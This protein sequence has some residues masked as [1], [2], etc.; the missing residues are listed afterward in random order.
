MLVVQYCT[1]YCWEK[2]F[3]ADTLT[4]YLKR[5][6]WNRCLILSKH[7]GSAV[8]KVQSSFIWHGI[9]F[10]IYAHKTATKTTACCSRHKA[11][12]YVFVSPK[13]NRVLIHQRR[14]TSQRGK[15]SSPS[16]PSSSPLRWPSPP[17]PPLV[18]VVR[19]FLRP[20][21]LLLRP[22]CVLSSDFSEG[23]V[24]SE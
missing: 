7:R 3:G 20:L 6:L 18:L 16:L 17:P 12:K 9:S 5:K 19:L 10:S 4:S 8:Q 23:A 22:R 2:K 14:R 24:I 15:W 11:S 1:W 21:R 13:N